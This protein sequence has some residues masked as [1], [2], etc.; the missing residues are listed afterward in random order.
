MDERPEDRLVDE[1]QRGG[2]EAFA[3]LVRRHE[4]RARAVEGL[5]AGE[6]PA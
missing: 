5:T 2:R 1:A 6:V 3:E 4:R